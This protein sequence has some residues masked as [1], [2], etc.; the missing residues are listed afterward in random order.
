MA[1]AFLLYA[2]PLLVDLEAFSIEKID[3]G[4]DTDGVLQFLLYDGAGDNDLFEGDGI[5]VFRFGKDKA[6]AGEKRYSQETT[7]N[8]P[9][10]F[11][12]L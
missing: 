5:G 2:E 1:C 8:L 9:V 11:Y 7:V 10:A 3:E 6:E 4:H 12:I